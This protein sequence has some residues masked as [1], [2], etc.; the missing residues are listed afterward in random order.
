MNKTEPVRERDELR[1][2][3][4]S[5]LPK[6]AGS[7]VTNSDSFSPNESAAGEVRDFRTSSLTDSAISCLPNSE[8]SK[9]H[10]GVS[11]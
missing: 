7:E 3:G 6:F 1:E 2:L 10:H 4:S 11:S 5:E 9:L 8:T